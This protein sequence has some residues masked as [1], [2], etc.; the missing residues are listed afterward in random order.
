MLGNDVTI[1]KTSRA[2]RPNRPRHVGVAL[3]V[4]V[5]LAFAGCGGDDPPPD[6]D[7]GAVPDV[8]DTGF[9]PDAFDDVTI[10]A[11]ATPVNAATEEDGVVAQ[12]YEITGR[13]PE[14]V[15]SDFAASLPGEGWDV[16]MPPEP[17]GTQGWRG[18]WVR[19]DEVLTISAAPFDPA[20]GA[21]VSQFSLVLSQST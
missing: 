9:A 4:V 2:S 1:M 15:L 17:S 11:G 6:A 13:S 18:E 16:A 12:T 8:A 21:R 3:A 7:Q 19:D 10:P 5:I 14:Q 20:D